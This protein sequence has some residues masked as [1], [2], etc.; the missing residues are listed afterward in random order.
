MVVAAIVFCIGSCVCLR[1]V[2]IKL[3]WIWLR[4]VLDFCCGLLVCLVLVLWFVCC[5]FLV[6]YLLIALHVNSVVLVL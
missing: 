1:L 4:V 2:A 6:V 5:D 3:V